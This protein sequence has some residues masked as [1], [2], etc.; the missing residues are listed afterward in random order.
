MQ[1]IAGEFNLFV[2]EEALLIQW[3]SKKLRP[4][5]KLLA[6]TAAILMR[7]KGYPG[8]ITSILRDDSGVHSVGRAVDMRSKHMKDEE[9]EDIRTTLN[10]W[11]PPFKGND[12]KMKETVPPLSHAGNAMQSTAPHLHLQTKG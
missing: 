1:P 7:I 6:R 3:Q 2:K 10:D 8:I 11:F 12:G 4:E 5:V 9:A